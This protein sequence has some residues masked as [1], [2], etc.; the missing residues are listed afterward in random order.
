MLPSL[1]FG[2][3]FAMFEKSFLWILLLI[4]N[5]I[6]KMTDLDTSN[7][8]LN[9]STSKQKFSFPKTDRF[10]MHGKMLYSMFYIDVI[11]SMIFP[12]LAQAGPLLSDTATKLWVWEINVISHQ[13]AHT[14]SVVNSK[15]TNIED[16]VLA[17]AEK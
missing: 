12:L 15:K 6:K 13:W 7:H 10:R 14:N 17:T 3:F 1:I 9:T 2:K 16:L 5:L 8:S 4:I 11:V